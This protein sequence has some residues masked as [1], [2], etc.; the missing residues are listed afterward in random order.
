M[1]AGKKTFCE[2]NIPSSFYQNQNSSAFST[3]SYHA[4][5]DTLTYTFTY[6]GN[7][8]YTIKKAN[9]DK[10]LKSDTLQES[11]PYINELWGTEKEAGTFRIT[12][13]VNYYIICD[14]NTKRI[15]SEND[16]N[17]FRIYQ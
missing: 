9:E 6:I 15:L 7:N 8:C 10:Y 12:R 5:T 2:W 13:K 1:T 3:D 14:V 17:T 4:Y 16:S 11:N